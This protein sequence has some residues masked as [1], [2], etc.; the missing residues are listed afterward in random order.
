[1][2]RLKLDNLKMK[3]GNIWATMTSREKKL[4]KKWLAEC[5]SV[6]QAADLLAMDAAVKT[7][8]K[9]LAIFIRD[10]NL[11]TAK[12]AAELA[13]NFMAVKEWNYESLPDPDR[14]GGKSSRKDGLKQANEQDGR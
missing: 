12:E 14:A 2:Y 4:S 5:Y 6:D 9:Q 11:R 10:R 1:M 8:P 3:S 13:D 7:M